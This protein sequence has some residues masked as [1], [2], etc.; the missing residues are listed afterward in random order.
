MFVSLET[1]KDRS[2]AA[3]LASFRFHFF[4]PISETN[5][6]RLF[7]ILNGNKVDNCC[8][9]EKVGKLAATKESEIV[10]TE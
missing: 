3:F 1:K 6:T 9:Q 8:I 7:Y 10:L 4:G 2:Y 5:R